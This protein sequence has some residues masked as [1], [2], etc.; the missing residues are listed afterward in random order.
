MTDLP[1]QMNSSRDVSQ[2]YLQCA[3]MSPLAGL[4]ALAEVSRDLLCRSAELPDTE[5]G[6]LKVLIEYRYAVYAFIAT[7]ERVKP[8][9]GA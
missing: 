6:L 2:S 7:A 3:E 1:S 9:A 5:Q 8:A 4:R